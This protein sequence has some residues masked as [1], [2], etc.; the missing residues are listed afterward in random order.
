MVILPITDAQHDYAQDL[1]QSLKQQGLRATLDLTQEKLG[2]KIRQN[3]LQKIPYLI[4]IG[5]QEM[6]KSAVRIRSLDGQDL[7]VYPLSKLTDFFNA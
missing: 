3:T 4:I 7:G 1:Y 6:Q 5:E 2:Y